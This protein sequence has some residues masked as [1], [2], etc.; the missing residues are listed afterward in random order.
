MARFGRSRVPRL[1][2]VTGV[3]LA[4]Q[5]SL[6]L[7]AS[8]APASLPISAATRSYIVVLKPGIAPKAVANAHASAFGARITHVYRYA[9]TGY[10]A[11]LSAVGLEL[12]RRDA[13]VAFV[14][15]DGVM[16]VDT[17]Q[18]DA[19][20][21]IDRIDQR[22]RPLS[23]TYSYTNTGSGV[24]AY[25]IDTG[26]RITHQDFGGRA[27]YGVDEI[28]GS[29]PAND[30]NSHG[31]HTAG[32]VGGTTYGVAKNVTLIAVRVLGCDGNGPTSGV[33]AGVDW[34]TGHHT[35]GPA[36]AN[37]SLGGGTNNALDTAVRNSITDGITYTFSAGNGNA[38]GQGLRACGQSPARVAE[39]ITVS[40]TTRQDAK[41]RWAN[42]GSCVD[43]FAPGVGITSDT[44]GSDTATG[45]KDG[46]SMAAPHVAGVAAQY[47]QS[48]PNATPAQVWSALYALTTKNIVTNSRTAA[49]N[50][51]LFTNL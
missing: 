18:N 9:V 35:G 5:T 39:G 31:T 38:F 29:L 7:G 15:A 49:H 22:N 17:T 51:L 47:L 10:A 45:V 41:P 33:I 27:F 37:M 23:T 43:L 19:T 30:C 8:A 36:V 2:L 3:V 21:G 46:T 13:R 40:A 6:T 12:V 28:D 50:D 20:W 26:I 34:V 42:Y 48:N 14:E 1:V 32:T 11:R 25:V 44:N 24:T 16:H 4:I